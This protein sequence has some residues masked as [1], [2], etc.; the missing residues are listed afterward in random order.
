MRKFC[1]SF[2]I[3]MTFFSGGCKNDIDLLDDYHAALVIYG[4]L[5]PADTVQYV[6]VSRV[7]LG[8][9]N[10]LVFAQNPDSTGFAPGTLS[11]KIEQW[12]NNALLNT[13]IL[14]ED[15]AIPRDS[16]IFSYPGQVLYRSAFPVLKD[17][18]IYKITATDHVRN[19]SANAETPIVGD[20]S[21]VSPGIF[22][23]L[24]LWTNS[25]IVFSWNTGTNG[26]RYSATLRFHYKEQFIYDTT[27]V[28]EK[29]VDW[30][31]GERDALDDNGNETV[32]LSRVRF[33]FLRMAS[34]RIPQNPV[35][36]RI[37]GKV[38]LIFLGAAE[39]FA[40]YLDV[41]AANQSGTA[42]IPPFSNIQNGYGLFSS[43]NP[44]AFRNYSLDSDTRYQLCTNAETYPLNFIR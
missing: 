23:P 12:K 14:A 44:T 16:G 43:R 24:N 2:L 33:D 25:N 26:K 19:I 39:N 17:G 20:V 37:A 11:V 27:E 28:T 4:I 30:D 34:Q 3:G 22:T 32:S 40:T 18:S 6:R 35:V 21:A 1:I 41:E 36:R 7:F 13:Y 10:A 42:S 8:E 9:G 5:N 29:Y 31:L 15:T 38:D